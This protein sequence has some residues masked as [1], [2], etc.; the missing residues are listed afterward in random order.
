MSGIWPG[1]TKCAVFLTFD[2]D[3]ISAL[4][5]RDP[6]LINR[7]S[8][9]SRN[10]FGLNVGAMRILD[11]L[12]KYG[13]PATFF[14][15]GYTAENNEDIV[16]EIA[17]RG[18]DIGH[19][20][21]LHEPAATLEPEEEK[22]ILEKGIQ[23]LEGI[24]GQRPYG[25]RSPSLDMSRHTIEFL[26]DREFLYDSS[27]MGNDAPHF[28][29]A[30][31]GRIVEFPNDWAQGDAHYYSYNRGAGAMNT[32]QE[33][34]KAWEWEFDGAYEYGSAL[35]LNIHPH[36]TGRLAKMMVFERLMKYIKGHSDVE[37]YRC[38]DVARAWTDQ[39]LR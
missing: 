15:P 24:T 3:G 22:A 27:M 35:I 7:P 19:H 11:V 16:K 14:I 9:I 37:F 23:I 29:D 39:G 25:Y 1:S 38:I 21:Y 17:R 10:E 33:V 20:G 2:L 28:V 18:H 5:N 32:P 13:L 36:T 12:D 8:M 4:L 6:E 31:N 34:Y 26:I 30:P